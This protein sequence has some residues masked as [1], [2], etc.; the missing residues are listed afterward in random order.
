MSRQSVLCRDLVGQGKETSC[1]DIRVLCHDRV[2]PG[3]EFSCR[4]IMFLCRDRVG[5]GGEALCCDRIFYVTTDL[6]VLG[7]HARECGSVLR[8]DRED[9][10]R[11]TEEFFCYRLVQ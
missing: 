5:N 6:G 3:Q 9:Q 1:L 8:C 2:W 10:A 11:V 7:W 4:D